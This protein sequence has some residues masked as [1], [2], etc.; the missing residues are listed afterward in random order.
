MATGVGRAGKY[1][2]RGAAMER[3][4]FVAE[5][6]LEIGPSKDY[7]AFLDGDFLGHLLLEH[8]GVAEETGYTDLGRVRVTVERVEEPPG[9]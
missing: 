8:F 1:F 9:S 7:F 4:A 6:K 5:G 2:V 3:D